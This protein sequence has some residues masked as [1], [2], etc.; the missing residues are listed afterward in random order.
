M[1]SQVDKDKNDEFSIQKWLQRSNMQWYYI[2]K[3]MSQGVQLVQ[4][5]H[6]CI[7]KCTSIALWRSTITG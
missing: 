1:M 2:K 7:K 6:N 4:N 5:F 3:Y